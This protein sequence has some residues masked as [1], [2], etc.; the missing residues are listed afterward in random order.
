MKNLLDG[1]ISRFLLA[2]KNHQFEDRLIEITQPE[3]WKRNKEKLIELQ[4]ITNTE[5]MG[6]PEWEIKE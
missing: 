6:V 3:E 1:L 4:G 5:I 2:E